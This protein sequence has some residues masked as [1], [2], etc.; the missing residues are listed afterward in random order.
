MFL[1]RIL[2]VVRVARVVARVVR[3]PDCLW[4]PG[5]EGGLSDP[6][7]R[8]A[9]LP[10]NHCHIPYFLHLFV[11]FWLLLFIALHCHLLLCFCVFLY[12]W[13]VDIWMDWCACESQVVSLFP[14]LLLYFISV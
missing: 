13:I 10:G 14:V 8:S 6:G 7:Q 9:R 4:Q 1:S 12:K 3:W 5:E 2:R 11:D